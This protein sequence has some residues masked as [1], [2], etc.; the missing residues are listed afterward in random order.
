MDLQNTAYQAKTHPIK[1]TNNHTD[2]KINEQTSKSTTVNPEIAFVLSNKSI[3][4]NRKVYQT[5]FQ[6]SVNKKVEIVNMN[7]RNFPSPNKKTRKKTIEIQFNSKKISRKSLKFVKNSIQRV[8]YQTKTNQKQP[9]LNQTQTKLNERNVEIGRLKSKIAPDQA[10]TSHN[11]GITKQI[12]NQNV[13]KYCPNRSK[14]IPN[15]SFII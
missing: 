11:Q 8:F 14:R 13:T 4:T 15:L 6:K 2:P 10:E 1:P 9:T 12:N 3:S 5:H 7:T